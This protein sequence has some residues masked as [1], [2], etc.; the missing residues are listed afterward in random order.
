M[1]ATLRPPL[2]EDYESIASWILDAEACRRWAGPK[3]SYPFS[4]AELPQLL[5]VPGSSSYCLASERSVPLGFGQFWPRPGG[6]IH[7]LRIIVSPTLRGK[8]LGR[9]LCGQLIARALATAPAHSLTLNVYRENERAVALYERLGFQ[10]VPEKSTG[11]S[12]FMAKPV[13]AQSAASG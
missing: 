10:V 7:L 2:L 1:T 4:A 6:V 12:L 9:E 13:P 3:V 8:G 5:A 11:N